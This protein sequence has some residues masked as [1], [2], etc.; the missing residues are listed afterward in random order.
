MT[1]PYYLLEKYYSKVEPG[2]ALDLGCGE[3]A[4]SVFLARQGFKVEAVDINGDYVEKLK[5]L[6]EKESLDLTIRK[7]DIREFDFNKEYNL[8]LAINSLQFM[9]KSEREEI[10]NKIKSFL[11]PDG[12]VS[13][14][15][16]TK[17]DPLYERLSKNHPSVEE[18]T[19]S[20]KQENKH[21]NFF[22][23]NELK[24]YF[25]DNFNILFYDERVVD[26]AHPDPHRHGIAEIV[27][28]K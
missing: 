1:Q 20:H 23:P 13:V 21:W 12:L 11:S 4:N 24:D 7:E 25:K 14:S 18:N 5:N 28:Q 3:G 6:S 9:K 10:V 15:V 17:E 16:F 8:I 26:D 22:N 27:A 19:F 2:K